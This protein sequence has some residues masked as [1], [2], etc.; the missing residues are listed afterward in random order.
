MD[1][2][3]WRVSEERL[4]RARFAAIRV[5]GP[6][7]DVLLDVPVQGDMCLKATLTIVP[8]TDRSHVAIEMRLDGTVELECEGQSR[9]MTIDS[10]G[11]TNIHA[12]KSVFVD[13][14][15]V[16]CLPAMCDAKS[17][18]EIKD[19]AQSRPR[20]FNRFKEH[21]ARQKALD[22]Q[23][24]AEAECSEHVTVA[25]CAGFDREVEALVK[26]V[27]AAL[28][29]HLRGLRIHAEL[30]GTKCNLRRDRIACG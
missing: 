12:A 6:F 26:A 14:A 4:R 21:L 30:G 15:G 22:R 16:K 9:G 25:I 11:V 2:F 19:I 20:L 24:E 17:S 27:N 29:D 5:E 7:E 28:R 8:I 3:D 10:R 1:E 23:E 18:L 13:A